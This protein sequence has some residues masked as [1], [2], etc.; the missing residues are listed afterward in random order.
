MLF[1]I[2]HGERADRIPEEKD[3]VELLFDPH[4]STL[5]VR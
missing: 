5:G 1:G 2:R 3:K 4:L